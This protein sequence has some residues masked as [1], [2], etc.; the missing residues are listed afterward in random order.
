M[1]GNQRNCAGCG[2][3]Y[4]GDKV[5]HEPDC[6]VLSGLSEA[7]MIENPDGIVRLTMPDGTII[8]ET[9]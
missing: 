4:S 9:V 7:R 8:G 5:E 2:Q 3:T 1:R 6:E